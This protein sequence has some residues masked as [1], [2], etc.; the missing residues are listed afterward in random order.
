M[1]GADAAGLDF[2]AN[3]SGYRRRKLDAMTN[4]RGRIEM[5]GAEM[6]LR[7]AMKKTYGIDATGLEIECGSFGKPRFSDASL[8]EFSLSH[9]EEAVAC[10]ISDREVGTDI[11][12]VDRL[13][14]AAAR[15]IMTD[16]EFE[17]F[18]RFDAKAKEE[19]FFRTWVL[20]ESL[21]KLTGNGFSMGPASFSVLEEEVSCGNKTAYLK[22]F[23]KLK[24][25]KYM[26][27]IASFEPIDTEPICVLF[28]EIVSFN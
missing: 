27:G 20:K 13:R 23:D 24:L 9:S 25:K 12:H 8:P 26:L 21:M 16:A 19:A 15:R 14:P 2:E 6:L 18:L 28:D 5:L 17:A 3:M 4:R 1:R 7:Y 22:C 10:A 11:Q